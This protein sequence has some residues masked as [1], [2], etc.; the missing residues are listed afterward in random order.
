MEAASE[1][2]VVKKQG[3]LQCFQLAPLEVKTSDWPTLKDFLFS[4]VVSE[5][6]SKRTFEMCHMDM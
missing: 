3:D 4:N 1:V 2:L 6:F 5:L